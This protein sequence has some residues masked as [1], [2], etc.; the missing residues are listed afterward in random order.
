MKEKKQKDSKFEKKPEKQKKE[1][2]K[3]KE[4]D[5]KNKF[6]EAIKKK[7]LIDQSKTFLLIVII[8]AIFFGISMGM[9]KLGLEPIDLSQEKLY[10]LTQA[11][12]D[13]LKNINKEVIMYFIEYR[14]DDT[15][16]D[17]AKQ[18]KKIN[19]KIK[20]ELVKGNDRPDL[21]QKY[22]LEAGTMGII[23]ESQEKSKVIAPEELVSY[24]YETY[25]PVNIAEEKLTAAIQSVTTD[26]KPKV[27]F[28]NG[29]SDLSLE[30]G[31]NLLNVFLQNEINEVKSVDLLA[32]GKV[33]DDCDTLVITTPIRDFDE[34]VTTSI[35][36]YINSGKNIL[37]FQAATARNLDLPNVNKIL[38]I[39]GISPFEVGIIR[40]ADINRMLANSPDVILPEV[41]N[42]KV[43]E[44]ISNQGGVILVNATKINMMEQEKL[45]ENK[46]TK[47]DL[48]TTSDKS[49]FRT[50][51]MNADNKAQE[52]EKQESYILGAM[53]EKIITEKNDETGEKGKKSKLI[54]YGDN[55]FISDVP[56]SQESKAPMIIERQNKDIAL[57]S[58][59]YLVDRE[60]DIVAR[61]TT[62]TVRFQATENEDRI[63]KTI[64]FIVPIIIIVIGIVICIKRKR[65]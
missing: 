60:E 13:K 10:T 53:M 4:K 1:I 2:V 24:D 3:N 6:I 40:E 38:E 20:V 50:N 48:L 23:V 43:T 19:E 29:Y 21:V 52:D 27:Y 54:I 22:G 65:Q 56:L 25:E 31:L 9:K 42:T 30:K 15:T 41:Q 47:T 18:Y 35:I 36:N 26:E 44:K 14:E 5:E 51:F 63:I 55:F 12:K 59:A 28:L 57:N 62:G 33:P 39:Y 46:I 7:W 32:T 34:G 64:I 37:W 11:S 61:K 17:L 45:A 16:L 8:V 49:Y 58:I